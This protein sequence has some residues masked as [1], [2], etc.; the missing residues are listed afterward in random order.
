[1]YP[2]RGHIGDQFYENRYKIKNHFTGKFKRSVHNLNGIILGN[3]L[4]SYS[5]EK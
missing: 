5:T 3:K 1:M 2:S 4:L